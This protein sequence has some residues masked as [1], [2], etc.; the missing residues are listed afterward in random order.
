MVTFNGELSILSR[1]HRPHSGVTLQEKKCIKLLHLHT[2][3]QA[4]SDITGPA[5]LLTIQWYLPSSA[6]ATLEIVSKIDVAPTI[7]VLFFC[8]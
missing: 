6:F 2:V 3:N 4:G 1:G 7:L 8:H 5:A